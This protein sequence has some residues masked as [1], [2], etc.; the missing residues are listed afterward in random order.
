MA[1]A[2][3]LGAARDEGIQREKVRIRRPQSS[4]PNAQVQVPAIQIEANAEHSQSLNRRSTY[5][6]R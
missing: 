4:R 6:D 5:N 1:R 2:L 3:V